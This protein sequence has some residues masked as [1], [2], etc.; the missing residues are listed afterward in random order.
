M[1]LACL[2]S[3]TA[4]LIGSS[5]GAAVHEWEAVRGFFYAPTPRWAFNPN[6]DL[7]FTA[8]V[9]PAIRQDCPGLDTSEM[10][11]VNAEFDELYDARGQLAGLRMV[12]GSGCRP[13]DEAIL[14][15]QREFRTKFH[16]PGRSDLDDTELELASG[17]DPASVRIVRRISNYQFNSGCY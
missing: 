14:L 12:K 8:N 3:A 11:T 5:L 7:E 15:G 16:T 17:V 6:Q 1:R 2:A 10:I 13:L 9:C 4:L